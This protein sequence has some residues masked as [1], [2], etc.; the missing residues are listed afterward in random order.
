MAEAEA[1]QVLVWLPHSYTGRGP[2]ESCVRI[3]EH[4]AE[5]GLQPTLFVNRA[6]K[7]VPVSVSLVE[8]A[9]GAL[10]SLPYRIVSG[11]A[12]ARLTR[13]FADAID[14]A[15]KGSIAY[16]WPDVPL[17]LVER[18]K[19]QGLICVREMINSPLA[20]A[21]PILDEAYRAAGLDPL[22][23]ITDA[24]VTAETREL[25]MQD[26]VFSANAEVDA[27]LAALGIDAKRILRSTFGWV[28]GRFTQTPAASE[29]RTDDVFRVVF[30]GL[31]NVRKG[32]PVLIDAWSMA[33]IDGELLLAGTVEEAL[34]PAVN[35]FC[36]RGD[37]THLGHVDDVAALYRSC[38]VFVFP[39]HEEGGPQVTYEAAA[40]GIPVITTPMGA[41]RLVVDGESGLLC[42]AGD[43]A[44]LAEALR[45]MAA[46]PRL[47]ARLGQNAAS[48]AGAFEYQAV[49]AQRVELLLEASH[50]FDE[51]AQIPA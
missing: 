48:L 31:M 9:G 33:G 23:D 20:H 50:R 30:V 41:A 14:R 13:L 21:K 12:T 11:A 35:R 36:Q 19:R 37:V 45:Q 44:A 16:F 18:A 5:H 29:T 10:R 4:F 51:Q 46:N 17:A 32:I 1:R 42:K 28:G 27:A 7:S 22:H 47:R 8:A 49:G 43:A 40:C 15:P 24:R 34:Q 2:A 26:F 39:T 38:D 25:L 6:K 3:V